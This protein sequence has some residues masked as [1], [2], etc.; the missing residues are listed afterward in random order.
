VAFTG[1]LSTTQKI[2]ENFDDGLA[3]LAK[4][5]KFAKISAAHNPSAS[6]PAEA[7]SFTGLLHFLVY[8]NL[9]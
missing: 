7:Q 8:Y 2:R 4:G 3:S 5:I 9:D 1:R 6:Q